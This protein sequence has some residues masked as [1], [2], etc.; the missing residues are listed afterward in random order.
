M[1]IVGWRPVVGVGVPVT[2]A[3]AG[4]GHW[5][6]EIGAGCHHCGKLGDMEHLVYP[7]LNRPPCRPEHRT[8]VL[9]KLE[10]RS[11]AAV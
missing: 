7:S 10:S 3:Y 2:D 11:H 4:L 6:L 1:G 9:L 5:R 8:L